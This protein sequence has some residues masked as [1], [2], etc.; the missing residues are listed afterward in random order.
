[1]ALLILINNLFA[2]DLSPEELVQVDKVKL[3]YEKWQKEHPDEDI[4]YYFKMKTDVAPCSHCAAPYALLNQVRKALKKM[5]EA[6][7]V[8]EIGE[9]ELQY[10][11]AQISSE[12]GITCNT[13]YQTF[14]QTAEHQKFDGQLKQIAEGI[15]DQYKSIA[16][17]NYNQ[18]DLK[19][20]VYYYRDKKNHVVQVIVDNEGK[21]KF[22][23]YNYVPKNKKVKPEEFLPDMA[24]DQQTFFQEAS[25][26]LLSLQKKDSISPTALVP[27]IPKAIVTKG[28]GTVDSFASAHYTGDFHTELIPREGA[29]KAIPK[30]VSF[31]DGSGEVDIGGEK[32][33][34]KVASTLS[35]GH[36]LDISVFTGADK[37]Q[38]ALIRYAGVTGIDGKFKEQKII[39]PLSL[40]IVDG[41][42]VAGEIADIRNSGTASEKRM[43]MQ[44]FEPAVEGK[45]ARTEYVTVSVSQRDG[46]PLVYNLQKNFVTDESIFT[47]SAGS[48]PTGSF[49]GVGI[50]P[51]KNP[52]GETIQLRLVD[53]AGHV[54]GYAMFNRLF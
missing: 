40:S 45:N 37:E 44:F 24:P 7:H 35:R 52:N 38:R 41:V 47:T 11:V 20:S 1:M 10:A 34:G 4:N 2:I 9:L 18:P 16:M 32:I 50:T 17:L 28:A 33:K 21:A 42:S 27:V 39:V 15:F 19:Q 51:K 8:P 22:R 23:I 46:Q 29:L 31:Y 14:D 26:Y 25:E 53:E 48:T 6:I 13:L 49:V 43:I 54:A 30:D 12:Q 3:D 36:Q 5:P